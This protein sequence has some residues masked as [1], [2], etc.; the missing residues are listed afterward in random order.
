M[1]TTSAFSFT[2]LLAACEGR[3][4]FGSMFG[5]G[6]EALSSL[7]ALAE[8]AFD[9]GRFADAAEIFEMLAV[10]EPER[11]DHLVRRAD[12]E[13]RAGR[14]DVAIACLNRYLARGVGDRLEPRAFE[15]RAQL[16]EGIDPLGAAVDR[17][18]AFALTHDVAAA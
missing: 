8:E 16:R 10:F 3:I 9:D 11:S 12:A 2:N 13:A 4:A 14:S 6:A 17:A 1:N 7:T 15:L 18:R 5:L